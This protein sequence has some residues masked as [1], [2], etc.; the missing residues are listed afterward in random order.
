MPEGLEDPA[1]VFQ[2]PAEGLQVA[3]AQFCAS[4]LSAT[5]LLRRPDGGVNFP[6]LQLPEKVIVVLVWQRD[7]SGQKLRR[8]ETVH[9][10]ERGQY[11][12]EK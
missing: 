4:Q 11:A 2:A 9:Q 6:Q 7:N 1:E 12:T 8:R 10:R 5:S 3:L